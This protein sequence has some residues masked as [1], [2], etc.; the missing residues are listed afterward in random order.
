MVRT[1]YITQY[2]LTKGIH[3]VSGQLCISKRSDG[4]VLDDYGGRMIKA[5]DGYYHKPH[6]HE[7]LE[8]A[9]AQVAKMV[10]AKIASLDKQRKRLEELRL[11][12]AKVVD[13]K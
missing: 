13:R 5:G 8:E 3:T 9:N 6:W 2:A 10:S 7:T 1:Y 11:N 4:S 12:G